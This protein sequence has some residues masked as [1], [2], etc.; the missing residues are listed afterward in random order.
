METYKVLEINKR[1]GWQKVKVLR[2][3]GTK[4]EVSDSSGYDFQVGQSYEGDFTEKDRIS[5]GRTYHNYYFGV[6]MPAEKSLDTPASVATG[7]ADNSRDERIMRGN[8]LNAAAAALAGFFAD[9]TRHPREMAEMHIAYAESLLP[10]LRGDNPVSESLKTRQEQPPIQQNMAPD[11]NRPELR[12]PVVPAPALAGEASGNEVKGQLV[13][14]GDL[15]SR[16][17]KRWGLTQTQ[18]LQ[19]L[20]FAELSDMDKQSLDSYWQDLLAI[21]EPAKSDSGQKERP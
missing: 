2:A 8:A 13:T 17:H 11:T 19:K 21:M 4:I 15:M 12:P 9:H 16:A 1:D 6:I 20:S 18:V 14:R 10:F 5:N 7:Q 3:D